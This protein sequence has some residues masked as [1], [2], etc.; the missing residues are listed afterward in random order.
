MG[1]FNSRTLVRGLNLAFT[2]AFT[3][4]VLL[5]LA[6]PVISGYQMERG[7]AMAKSSAKGIF[8]L[9][10]AGRLGAAVSRGLISRDAADTL[11]TVGDKSGRFASYKVTVDA[12]QAGGTPCLLL[13]T[14]KQ[15]GATY[16][17]GLEVNWGFCTFADVEQ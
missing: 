15:G 7:T 2:A 8:D 10:G 6:L 17:F 3:L 16:K 11:R 4:A 13:V 5:F 12:V 14:A 9:A 1:R